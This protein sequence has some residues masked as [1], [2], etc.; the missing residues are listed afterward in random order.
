MKRTPE[1][2]E[3]SLRIL[4]AVFGKGRGKAR[5]SLD[6]IEE[7]YK[8]AEAAQPITAGASVTSCS[9]PDSFPRWP[10]RKCSASTAC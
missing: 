4:D 6:L 3:T 7:M 2:F 10:A 8:T 5:R 1:H 9:P